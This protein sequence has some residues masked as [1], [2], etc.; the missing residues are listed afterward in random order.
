MN[1]ICTLKINNI[2]VDLCEVPV[3]DTDKEGNRNSEVLGITV[4]WS[5]EK[6]N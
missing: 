2:V 4:D 5:L 6:G 3:N 1:G